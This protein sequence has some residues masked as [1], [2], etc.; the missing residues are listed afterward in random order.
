MAKHRDI[1]DVVADDGDLG[2]GLVNATPVDADALRARVDAARERRRAEKKAPAPSDNTPPAPNGEGV[3]LVAMLDRAVRRVTAG[4]LGEQGRVLEELLSPDFL[5]SAARQT[6]R[7]DIRQRLRALR[8]RGFTEDAKRIEKALDREIERVDN[9][10]AERAAADDTARRRK[11]ARE[12]AERAAAAALEEDWPIDRRG[13]HPAV[14]LGLDT[15]KEGRPKACHSNAFKIIRDDPR[16]GPRLRLNKLG[17][18]VELHEKDVPSDTLFTTQAVEWLADNYAVQFGPETVRPVLFAVAELHGYSPVV[19]YLEGLPAWDGTPRIAKVLTEVLGCPD[20]ALHQKFIRRM[21]ISAVARA[22]DPGCK[23]DTALVLIGDQGARKSTFFQALFTHSWFGSSP[24][25]I[26]DKNAPI[27]LRSTWGYEAAEME[28]LSKATAEG[29]K[30]FLSEQ[31]DLFRH[32]YEKSAKAWPRHSIMVATTNKVQF[33]VDPTGSRRFWPI[34][35][36]EGKRVD[37][38]LLTGLRSLLWA[39]ALAAYRIATVAIAAGTLPGEDARWWLEPYEEGERATEAERFEV[40]DVW[41]DVVTNWAYTQVVP[42]STA[43]VL[44]K[45]LDFEL[46]R[47]DKQSEWRIGG[48]LTRNGFRSYSEL[49]KNRGRYVRKWKQPKARSII[50]A[51]VDASFV[52]MTREGIPA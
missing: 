24:I 14:V 11:V 36:P 34:E 43:D 46:D 45:A 8:V 1:A 42:F 44:G 3:D 40:T 32:I 25:P 13:P 49:D 12:I 41:E 9:G 6:D 48:I 52:Q 21:L 4:D 29:V 19:D 50:A 35:I 2:K 47:M 15:T 10:R 22:L 31:R 18:R 51:P 30:Q 38:A 5:D 17:D 16:W 37:V 23:V 33:L 26:G 7:G 20:N 28:S 27:Q 39:E